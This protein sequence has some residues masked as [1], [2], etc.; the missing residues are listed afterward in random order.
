MTKSM[1]TLAIGILLVGGVS[2]CASFVDVS[3]SWDMTLITPRGERET[4]LNFEQDGESIKVTMPSFRGGDDMTG[5]GTVTADKIQ[6]TFTIEGP[7][8]D[9]TLIYTGTIEGDSMSGE[10]E[11]GEMGTFEWTAKKK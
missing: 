2:L 7:Q 5:E 11:F 6:W 8:G 9:M 1:K 10:A 4:E 3:G